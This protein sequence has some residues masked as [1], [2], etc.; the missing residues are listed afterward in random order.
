MPNENYNKFVVKVR[1]PNGSGF[2]PVYVLPDATDKI[3]GGV[4]LSDAVNE[5]SD[6]ETG[7]VAATPAAVKSVNENA[8]TKLSMIDGK[9][10]T[11]ASDVTFNNTVTSNG[12]FKGELTGNA[13]T[14]SRLKSPFKISVDTS[15]AGVN[16]NGV[17]TV[18]TDGTGEAKLVINGI[19]ASLINSGTIGI[20][21][22]PKA[23]LERMEIVADDAARFKLTKDKVQNGDTIYVE[24]KATKQPK[25]YYVSDETK[26]SSEDGYKEYQAGTASKLGVVQVGS[27]T[28][29]M[30]I[31]DGGTPTE[32]NGT[33]GSQTKPVYLNG[34]VITP[35][36]Y[37]IE[38]SVPNDAVFTDTKYVDM[39]GATVSAAGKSGLVPAPAEGDQDKFLKADGTWDEAGKVKSVNGDIG[40]VTITAASLGALSL[41]GGTMYGAILPSDTT[42]NIGGTDNKFGSIYANTFNGK[43]VGSADSAT[44]AAMATNLDKSLVF[45]GAI[46]SASTSLSQSSDTITINTELKDN[47]VTFEKLAPE[48]KG[49][50]VSSI[51]PDSS[52][53]EHI[54]IWVK[55]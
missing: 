32:S 50:Y 10:Q 49:V 44:T 45:S 29:F 33:V 16:S 11:V 39:V 42:V 30:Y 6:A 24:N 31:A 14:A 27:N 51:Q 8:E 40:D 7:I 23:A 20:D 54:G 17:V 5:T 9:A 36:G 35:I 4:K 13:S 43:L 26:L 19:D 3:K 15:N 34:G 38:K 12:G 1:D 2:R 53:A 46:S 22:I 55:I 21:R 52:I 25:M 28:K 18:S 41:S 47:S 37:T 48:V